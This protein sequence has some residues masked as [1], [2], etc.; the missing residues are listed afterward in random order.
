MNYDPVPNIIHIVLCFKCRFQTCHHMFKHS[1]ATV[2]MD[3]L[4]DIS[5]PLNNYDAAGVN[6]IKSVF[7]ENDRI[8]L[9]P[10]T[11]APS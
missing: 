8:L 10:F 11:P 1:D 7:L 3:V 5:F 6:G 2:Q 4:L 9:L